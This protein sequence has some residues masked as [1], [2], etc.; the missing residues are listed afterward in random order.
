MKTWTTIDKTKWP[1]RGEW[2]KEPDKA[3][4]IDEKTGLDCLITRNTM[5]ALCGYVGVPEAHPLFG[6]PCCDV[7]L[8]AHGSVNFAD[9]CDPDADEEKGLCHTAQDAANETVWWFGFDCSHSCDLKPAFT[10][11]AF[12]MLIPPEFAKMLAMWDETYRNFE[13]V[14]AEVESL[15]EQ[16]MEYATKK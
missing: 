5:G 15:A 11:P 10:M 4:W 14:K 16:L 12:T 13:F 6:K 8:L 7:S 9:R 3:H 1:L 2:D